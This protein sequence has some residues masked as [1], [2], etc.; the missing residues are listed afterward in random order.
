LVLLL[1]GLL[2]LRDP[3]AFRSDLVDLPEPSGL[4]LFEFQKPRLQLSTLG[5]FKSVVFFL[6]LL[7][8]F[9]FV[10]PLLCLGELLQQRVFLCLLSSLVEVD[11][12]LGLVKVLGLG[13]KVVF[14]HLKPIRPSLLLF[15]VP[16]QFVELLMTVENLSMVG[17]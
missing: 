13:L 4:F 7:V 16:C 17:V 2:G 10:D 11:L 8:P 15:E 6:L 3:V 14:F 1:K 5:D 9:F 12:F